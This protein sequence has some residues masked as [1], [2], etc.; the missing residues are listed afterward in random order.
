MK[1]SVVLW[2]LCVSVPFFATGCV[3]AVDAP[4]PGAVVVA[5]GPP[6]GPG[7]YVE[8]PPP[9]AEV[10]VE[11]PPVLDVQDPELVVVP[12]GDA[13]VYMMPS[14]A[15]VYFYDGFWYRY[16]GGAW[17]RAG[18]YNG[19]WVGIAV[20][21][22]LVVAIDPFYPFYL[23]AGYFRIGWGDFHHHWRDW[24][25]NHHWHHNPHFRHEMRRDVRNSRM[26]QIRSDRSRGIDRS[27]GAFQKSGIKGSQYKP[28][29]KG[30]QF[31]KN[32]QK[33]GQYNKSLQKGG[34]YKTMQKSGQYNK[35]LQKG[36]QYKT[37][38]KSGQY[39]KSLQKGGQYKSMQN[40]NLQKS[41]TLKG[42]QNI[43]RSA[44]AVRS[45]GGKPAAKGGHDHK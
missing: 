24:G 43:Q 35:S 9:A 10:T 26:R 14:V 32:L 40:R 11:A 22:P 1:K 2:I 44:P 19:P 3:V 30:S 42:G 13:Y 39:N 45:G 29:T 23:P 20:A 17:F 41:G 7:E 21:P 27:K 4:P 33:G 37:M 31:N 25:H 28:P 5:P 16:Y 12:S 38:Q 36:G 18:I 8:G 6:P 15:G 34:Q